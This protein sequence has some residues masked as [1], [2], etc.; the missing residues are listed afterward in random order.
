MIRTVQRPRSNAG[1]RCLHT[2]NRIINDLWGTI[3]Y[4][5]VD[6]EYRRRCLFYCVVENNYCHV[7]KIR[8]YPLG[9]DSLCQILIDLSK[10][11]DCVDPAISMIKLQHLGIGPRANSWLNNRI[12]QSMVDKFHFSFRPGKTVFS[13]APNVKMRNPLSPILGPI[14]FSL[15]INGISNFVS[16]RSNG[17]KY[18]ETRK[19]NYWL[20]SQKTIV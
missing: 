1:Y 11:F 5:V 10:A 17:W 16:L 7:Y 9:H 6:A 3:Y 8:R 4:V 15:Y 2:C 13:Q 12:Q 18:S 19:A 14:L 20:C